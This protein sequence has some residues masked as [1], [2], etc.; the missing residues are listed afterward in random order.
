MKNTTLVYILN[1]TPLFCDDIYEKGYN[2]LSPER[3]EKTDKLI[4]KEDKLLSVGA[5][6]L[7][8]YALFQNGINPDKT[9]F[10]KNENGKPYIKGNGL[11][12]NISHSGEYVI[13]G[14]SDKEIGCDIQ[15]ITSINEKVIKKCLDQGEIKAL[16]KETD[17]NK[18]FTKLWAKK[19]SYVKATGKGIKSG[20]K[21]QKGTKACY[22]YEYSDILGYE[23]SVC[24]FSKMRVE[25]LRVNLTD[26]YCCSQ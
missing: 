9:E 18:A 1:I 26:I 6:L 24:G 3:K 8:N 20:L 22:F 19:E 25:F 12:F 2:K 11:Y 7:R 10:V 14:V 13:C 16:E 21:D 4:K 23:C 17:K 5:E 15:K